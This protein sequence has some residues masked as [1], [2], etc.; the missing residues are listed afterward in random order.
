M[1]V[2][3]P[4]PRQFGRHP[5]RNYHDCQKRSLTRQLVNLCGTIRLYHDCLKACQK[6][7]LT[8][9]NWCKIA[10]LAR[11]VTKTKRWQHITPTL[12]ELHWLPIRKRIDYKVLMVTFRAVHNLAPLA[13]ATLLFPTTQLAHYVPNQNISYLNNLSDLN[14][15]VVGPFQP[16]PSFQSVIDNFFLR[17]AFEH[18]DSGESALQT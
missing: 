4:L 8:V 6:H 18:W 2:Y 17:S 13:C 14:R 12:M 7:H 15:L 1:T 9:C 3:L 16:A 10:L 11:L 5:V